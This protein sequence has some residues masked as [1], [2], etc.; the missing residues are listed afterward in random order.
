MRLSLFCLVLYFLVFYNFHCTNSVPNFG[1]LEI[2]IENLTQTFVQSLK[3]RGKPYTVTDSGCKGL[4]INVGAKSK[5]FYFK[6]FDANGK[7]GKAK[8]GDTNAL[9]VAQARQMALELKTRITKGETVKKEKPAE[10]LTLGEFLTNTYFPIRC[11]ELK[12]SRETARK[13]TANFK[14]FFNKPIDELDADAIDKWIKQRIDSGAKAATVNKIVSALKAALNWG[15]KT[16]RIEINPITHIEKRKE[17]DSEQKIRFLSDDERERLESAL[18]ARDN[19]IHKLNANDESGVFA[20]F[21]YP[22]VLLSLNT[23]IRRNALFNLKW[24]DIDLSKRLIILRP[25]ISKN[26][27]KE[28]IDI[29]DDAADVL[30][31][32]QEQNKFADDNDLVFPEIKGSRYMYVYR[33]WQ[34]VLKDAGIEKFRWHDMRHDFASQLVMAGIDIYTVC[35]ML[36]H[37]DV[38]ITMKYAHLAPDRT[39]NAVQALNRR[40]KGD[41][42][43]GRIRKTSA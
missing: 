39:K 18:A 26:G 4:F 21:L 38:R 22:A 40:T 37:S 29:N 27:K 2:V 1:R 15:V 33:E 8:I 36:N 43:I 25:E 30:S 7:Q 11:N 3:P 10:K 34:A 5:T 32:W 31:S 9:T 24:F 16:K 14:K 6:Y 28:L 20:D 17:F 41:K 23:G 12:S 35:K 19:R 42:I 13:I